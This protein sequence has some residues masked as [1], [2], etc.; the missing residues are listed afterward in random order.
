MKNKIIINCILIFILAG[1]VLFVFNC[2]KKKE[3]FYQGITAFSRGN[4]IKSYIIR[5]DNVKNINN[6]GLVLLANC[7][8]F[9]GKAYVDVNGNEYDIPQIICGINVKIV[10][11]LN[12]EH[13]IDGLNRISYFAEPDGDKYNIFD[14][15]IESVEEKTAQVVDQTYHILGREISPN[16]NTFDFVMNYKDEYKRKE[17]ELPD[18]ARRGKIRFYRAGIYYDHVDRMIEMFKEAYINLVLLQ[19]PT[20]S[21]IN[22]EEYKRYKNFIDRCH[23]NGIKIMYDGGSSGLP[24]RLN[25]I[26]LDAV[27]MHPEWREWI[28]KD[29]YGIPRWRGK[30]GSIFLPN[31]KN[32]DY[33]NECLKNTEIAIDAGVD[34]LYYDWAIGR[35]E[36]LMNFFLRVRDLTQ[37]KGK[38][39]TIY[40]NTH[41]HILVDGVCDIDKSEGTAEPGISP[42]G[43]WIH[44]VSQARFY[45][46]TGD[47]WKP[48]ESK[49]GG[50]RT[51]TL[52]DG[53]RAGWQ[54]PLAEASAF[55]SH[56]AIA[57]TGRKL[58]DGWVLK[59]NKIALEIWDDICQ[60][61][62]FLAENEEFYTEVV[63]VSEIGL[64][65]PPLVPSF[66]VVLE[67][68]P[69]YDALA[70]MN[71]M[72]DVLLLPRIDEDKLSKYK[73]IVVPDI[74]W[75]DEKQLKLIENYKNSG[76]KI[77]TIGSCDDLKKLAVT[78]SPTS[79][80][81]EI[82][83]YSTRMEFLDNLRNLTG[84][85]IITIEGAK[86]V[87]SNVVRKIGTDK[88][89]LHLINYSEHLDNIKIKVNLEGYVNNINKESITLY[90]PD[91]VP[92]IIK[93]ISVDGKKIEFTIP[94]LAIY[95]VVVIN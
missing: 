7:S 20:P 50:G 70:E 78:I 43:K 6:P 17:S 15:C 75:V 42:D 34:E 93:D 51:L 37:K 64:L 10:V 12:S 11:P 77:Y 72:Y 87:I 63:T 19:V 1:A 94:R 91:D 92:K 80:G 3:K 21:D 81:R 33:I 4:A 60:Y 39:I 29:E 5:I 13:L 45:Y 38:N 18:W 40:A 46:A 2:E 58:S 65:A 68:E 14:T 67:R 89:I 90:S 73:T 56:F 35:T 9:N 88:I 53:M 84:E 44:N 25:A 36:E 55:Q 31:L 27:I 79:M 49:Y 62:K 23:A 85:P 71:I 30:P 22:S 47:G 16:I 24:V 52:R 28:S 26:T 61:N 95:D 54:R 76:G 83:N 86:Y 69:I 82:E 32:E 48:Y 41:G 66:F 8:D 59:N 57:E 74:P